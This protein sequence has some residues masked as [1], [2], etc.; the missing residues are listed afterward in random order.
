MCTA[1]RA[2]QDVMQLPDASERLQLVQADLLTPGAFDS[3]VQGC[4]GVIHTASP[5]IPYSENVDSQTQLL[6]PAVK[7]TIN[8]L[9]SCAKAKGV[10]R[11][12]LTSSRGSVA[13]TPH[14]A[15]GAVLDESSWSDVDSN[16]ENQRWYPLSKFLAEKAAWD[17][18]KEH[19]LEKNELHP[20]KTTQFPPNTSQ[21]SSPRV[22]P[23]RSRCLP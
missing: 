2:N 7:G 23:S 21:A 13:Y 8:V 5:V 20:G 16:R 4:D 9:E 11:V 10:K 14:R 22:E 17:F 12:V 19:D 18:A 15:S 6:V 3:V 1:N